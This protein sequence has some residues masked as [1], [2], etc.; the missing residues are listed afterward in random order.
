ME[1]LVEELMCEYE[2]EARINALIVQGEK[3]EAI[4]LLYSEL[5]PMILDGERL[6]PYYLDW[7]RLMTPIEFDAWQT[8]RRVGVPMWPQYPVGHVFVDFGDPVKKIAV[9]CDGKQWH[10]KEKDAKRDLMLTALGW[11][12][13]RIP[14]CECYKTAFDSYELK[15]K[16]NDGAISEC[17][18]EHAVS[19]WAT[20]TSD[21]VIC[22]IGLR[23]YG[24]KFPKDWQRHLY[25]STDTHRSN[26]M[27]GVE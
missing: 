7:C 22:G 26:Y 16:Y 21:G 4:R 17:E 2:L 5:T 11:K 23:Y 24:K 12:V 13:F 27:R 20:T 25:H 15:E 10:I 19:D 3:W 6:S 9:E 14:G 8:I 1:L 18:Y